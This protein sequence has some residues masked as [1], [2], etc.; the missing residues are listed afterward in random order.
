LLFQTLKQ[1]NFGGAVQTTDRVYPHVERTA[2]RNHSGWHL[3]AGA[4][5]YANLEQQQANVQQTEASTAKTM[6]DILGNVFVSGDK[7]VKL[8]KGGLMPTGQWMAMGENAP[9]V[10]GGD[11]ASGYL[12][13]YL[14]KYGVPSVS[15]TAG[16]TEGGA[17]AADGTKPAVATPAAPEA[18][19]A[20][21]PFQPSETTKPSAT[22]GFIGSASRDLSK[23]D[24]NNYYSPSGAS[25]LEKSRVYQDQVNRAASAAQQNRVNM[26]DLAK[27]ISKQAPQ[28]G[29]ETPGLAFAQ[30]AEV[31]R[32]LDT[33]S[34]GLGGQGFSGAQNVKDMEAKLSALIATANSAGVGSET[35][36][37]LRMLAEAIPNQKMNPETQA[38]LAS[39]LMVTN[40][41]MIDRQK[42]LIDYRNLPENRYVGNLTN[43]SYAFDKDNSARIQA[44]QQLIKRAILTQP[45][46]MEK[47]TTGKM[48][49]DQIDTFFHTLARDYKLQYAPGMYRYFQ[50]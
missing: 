3:G 6:S 25:E 31:V 35:L 44:D 41:T 10:F 26:N 43:A 48:K 45:A 16:G 18:P 30:R 33:L 40:R 1:L 37:A 21:Q 22:T 34:R 17:K 38:E 29:F 27:V 49:P 12:R 20:P 24:A 28:K 42:H 47:I 2:G 32:A 23:T 4:Q 13:Q 5:A 50:G 39:Q 8:A 19:E 36:G 9:A 14:N 15:D 7:F 46:L 11:I